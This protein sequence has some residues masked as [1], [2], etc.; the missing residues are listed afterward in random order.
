M[1]ISTACK[2]DHCLYLKRWEVNGVKHLL[3]VRM[4]VDD[5]TIAGSQLSSVNYLKAKLSEKFT[6]KDLV[7]TPQ[8]QSV[9]L[10]KKRTLTL[11]QIAAQPFDYRDLVGH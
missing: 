8:A 3:I 9:V 6:V 5:L 1:D 2:N 10:E 11:D 4:Y 7:S